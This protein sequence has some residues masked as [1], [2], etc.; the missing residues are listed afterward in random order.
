M[1]TH[2]LDASSR[3]ACD[4]A[5][6]IVT[7]PEADTSVRIVG[8][9][10]GCAITSA[11]GPIEAAKMFLYSLVASLVRSYL[12]MRACSWGVAMH[13]GIGSQGGK[14]DTMHNCYDLHIQPAYV[15]NVACSSSVALRMSGT[16]GMGRVGFGRSAVSSRAL[17]ASR[18]RL[19]DS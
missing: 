18:T 4:L 1:M 2:I 15:V 17:Q 19:T 13:H 12:R 8:T 10:A 6:A 5:R 9:V 11:P 7:M 3:G 14:R 16:L